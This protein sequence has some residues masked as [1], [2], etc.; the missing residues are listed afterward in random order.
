MMKIFRCIITLICFIL[1]HSAVGI[2]ATV[3]NIPIHLTVTGKGPQTVILVHGWTCNET[4]WSMQVP[5]L[6][7]KYRVITI[8]L[9][10][11]GKSGSPKDGKFSIEL[12]VRAI[13][14][15]RSEANAD[16]A[17]FVGHS[18]GVPVIF[19]YARMCPQ[20]VAALVFV[21]GGLSM[22]LKTPLDTRFADQFAG[23][24][25]LK[26]R[27][28][29]IRSMFSPATTPEIEKHILSMMLGAPA[30]TAV[31]A[32]KAMFDPFVWKEEVFYQPALGIY[33][34]KSMNIDRE[35]IKIHFP[36]MVVQE[37]SGVGHFL[38]MEKPQEFNRSL[39]EFL[40]KLNY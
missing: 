23:L 31:G 3:D 12:F 6:S 27:E 10:G 25:G 16:K 38:M 19:N 2:A 40:S 39:M 36:N 11:H 28:A 22:Q 21:D 17:V 35:Y 33:P 29:M 34:E 15:V 8:D 26:S 30:E 1:L 7:E 20:H 14:A 5:A 4:S 37:F 24:N 13:E 32:M 9:P 18:M